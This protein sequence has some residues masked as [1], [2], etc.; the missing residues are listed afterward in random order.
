[1]Q[2]VKHTSGNV[3]HERNETFNVKDERQEGWGRGDLL[4]KHSTL[5]FCFCKYNRVQLHDTSVIFT[6]FPHQNSQGK[7]DIIALD[8]GIMLDK[9]VN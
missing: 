7:C 3:S 8:C 1:M 5:T 4:Q 2:D 9:Q 6:R